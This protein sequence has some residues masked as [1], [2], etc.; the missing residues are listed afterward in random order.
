MFYRFKPS[1]IKDEKVSQTHIHTQL[2]IL[3]CFGH[4]LQLYTFSYTAVNHYMEQEIQ[5]SS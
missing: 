1:V 5:F 4:F 3:L 2:C